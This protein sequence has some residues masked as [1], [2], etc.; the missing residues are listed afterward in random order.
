MTPS[1]NVEL[2]RG[3]GLAMAYGPAAGLEIIGVLNSEPALQDCHLLP[4]V[5]GDLL[6]KLGCRDEA[7]AE[8]ERAAAL[9]RNARERE[10]LM[11]RARTARLD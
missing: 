3:V 10:L 1:P 6:A 9:T 5:R 8:F 11:E 4:S 7:R 2:N